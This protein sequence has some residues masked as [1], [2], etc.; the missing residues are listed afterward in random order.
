MRILIFAIAVA[1]LLLTACDDDEMTTAPLPG[2]CSSA[3]GAYATEVVAT[4]FTCVA[5]N[6]F[7][8]ASRAIGSPDA[9]ATGSGKTQLEGVVSPGI[10][11]SITLF[12]GSCVQDLPG[13][14]LRVYQVVSREAVEVQVSRNADG[15]YISLGVLPCNDPPPYF[16]GFCEFDLANSGLTEIRYVRIIDRET[17]VFPQAACDNTGVSPGADIDAV[18][19]LHPVSL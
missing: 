17:I 18:Q 7:M 4:N 13:G 10:N 19:N 16:N 5:T 15:P 12:M 9:R 1:V 11:G 14:D 3:A 8:D 2:G 6:A